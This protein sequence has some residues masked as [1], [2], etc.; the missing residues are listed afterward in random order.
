MNRRATLCVAVCAL[1][2]AALPA[3]AA[4]YKWTDENGR[5]VYGDT[6]LVKAETPQ[7]LSLTA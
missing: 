3:G 4:L 2:F 5:I 1:A 6:P 7:I